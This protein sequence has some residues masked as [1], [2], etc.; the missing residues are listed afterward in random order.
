M[1][2]DLEFDLDLPMSGVPGWRNER[3]QMLGREGK[4]LAG[5]RVE[6][7]ATGRKDRKAPAFPGIDKLSL[8]G[9]K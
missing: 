9:G 5:D 4:W 2:R 6:C 7:H 1:A 8:C 3:A